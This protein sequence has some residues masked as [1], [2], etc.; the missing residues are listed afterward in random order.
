MYVIA[1]EQEEVPEKDRQY[2]EVKIVQ[3]TEKS[4]CPLIAGGKTFSVDL[5]K[6]KINF[7]K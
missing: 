4:C 7:A 3:A 5:N 2:F 6:G 1:T